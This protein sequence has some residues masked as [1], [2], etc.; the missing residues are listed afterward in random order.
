[1]IRLIIKGRYTKLDECLDVSISQF[2]YV[3]EA[4]MPNG[5]FVAGR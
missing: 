4:G 2:R 1:M 5:N 3:G